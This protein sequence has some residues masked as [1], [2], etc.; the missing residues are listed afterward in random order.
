MAAS[1]GYLA[2][3]PAIEPPKGFPSRDKIKLMAFDAAQALANDK[4]NKEKFQD[5]FGG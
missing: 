4:K 5:V 1:Q 3:H 2:A